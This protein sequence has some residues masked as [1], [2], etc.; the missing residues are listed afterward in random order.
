VTDSTAREKRCPVG[1][2]RAARPARTGARR[3]TRPPRC[4]V[5][6]PGER[7]PR[8]VTRRLPSWPRTWGGSSTT[9][10]SYGTPRYGARRGVQPGWQNAP[11]RVW[12]RGC[13]HR[14]WG[15][16]IVGRRQLRARD[17][18]A[19]PRALGLMTSAGGVGAM[20]GAIVAGR[21]SNRLGL[22]P[23]VIRCMA[24]TLVVTIRRAYG[25]PAYAGT[26]RPPNRRVRRSP[27]GRAKRARGRY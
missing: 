20:F 19:E 16:A 9:N 11:D 6:P 27:P 17:P 4:S 5:R 8:S 3:P 1:H 22:G 7:M 15:G 10:R 12:G 13:F 21:M 26:T 18:A 14:G 23:A 2:R 24:G 25:R